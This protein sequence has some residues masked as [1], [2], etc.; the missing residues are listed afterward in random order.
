MHLGDI[1]TLDFSESGSQKTCIRDFRPD[2]TQISLCS[3]KNLDM[4]DIYNSRQI[5]LPMQRK[6]KALNIQGC[7]ADDLCLCLS[8]CVK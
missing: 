5:I 8:I 3:L 6:A 1:F 2:K 4:S 7:R